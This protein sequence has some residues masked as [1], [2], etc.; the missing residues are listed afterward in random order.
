MPTIL[1]PVLQLPCCGM[2]YL[3]WI[4]IPYKVV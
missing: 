2:E 1:L 4:A 3:C